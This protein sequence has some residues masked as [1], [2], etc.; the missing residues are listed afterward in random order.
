MAE[1]IIKDIVCTVLAN[2]C[3]KE[4]IYKVLKEYIPDYEKL[5][6]KDY[7]EYKSGKDQEFKSEDEVIDFFV[8]EYKGDQNFYWNQIEGNPDKIMVGVNI[9]EDNYLVVSLTIDGIQAT[10]E[11]YYRSLKGLLNA[12]I[13]VISYVNP[14]D[15]EDGEDFKKKYVRIKYEFE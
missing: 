6:P 12:K 15:Y 11:K 14:A 3:S 7:E 4:N 13:G 9:T 10:K 1:K 8:T 2:E 5:N